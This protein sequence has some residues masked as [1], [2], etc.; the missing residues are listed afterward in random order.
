MLYNDKTIVDNKVEELQGVPWF[1]QGFQKTYPYLSIQV[2][3]HRFLR[4][5]L[6]SEA[7]DHDEEDIINKAFELGANS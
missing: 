5:L 2:K 3:I 1:P 6:K 4:R 7:W